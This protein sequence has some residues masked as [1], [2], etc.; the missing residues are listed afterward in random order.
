MIDKLYEEIAYFELAK[1]VFIYPEGTQ[2]SIMNA[3]G[4]E[5]LVLG[6]MSMPYDMA[7]QCPDWFKPVTIA[8]HQ[9]RCRENLINYV[10]QKHACNRE[11]AVRVVDTM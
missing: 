3:D 4:R 11:R 7:L 5:E 8:E 10:M 9:E 6:A 2:I 1:P